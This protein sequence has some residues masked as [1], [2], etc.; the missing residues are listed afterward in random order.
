M[1]QRRVDREVTT[2][3][4]PLGCAAEVDL[5]F[6][7]LTS[8]RQAAGMEIIVLLVVLRGQDSE[9]TLEVFCVQASSQKALG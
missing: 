8:H 1:V 4:L 9:I 3:W 6:H 5:D 2:D 7:S